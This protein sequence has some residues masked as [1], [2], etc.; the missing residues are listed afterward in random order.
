MFHLSILRKPHPTASPAY[1]LQFPGNGY[2]TI[3][4]LNQFLDNRYAFMFSMEFKVNVF[5]I[6]G[7]SFLMNSCLDKSN[8]QIGIAISNNTL[9]VQVNKGTGNVTEFYIPF[10]DDRY[11]HT[12]ILTNDR[13]NLSAYL[14]DSPMLFNSA[15]SFNLPPNLGFRIASSTAGNQFLTGLVDNILITNI[16]APIAQYPLNEGTGTTAYDTIGSNNGTITS[17][18][19]LLR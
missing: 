2:I 12:I 14:D 17:G 9:F 11:W 19:W 1:C 7:V 10:D 3:N 13:G 16:T 4:P 5:P 18:T 6:T 15:P 8:N